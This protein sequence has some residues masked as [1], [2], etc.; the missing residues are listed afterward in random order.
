MDTE[1]GQEIIRKLSMCHALV[2]AAVGVA[3]HRI[4]GHSNINLQEPGR[5]G[6]SRGRGAPSCDCG[7][8]PRVQCR[9]ESGQT[10]GGHLPGK[11]HWGAQGQ[12]A[13]VVIQSPG[14]GVARVISDGRDGPDVRHGVRRVVF[15]QQHPDGGGAPSGGA[16]G[17]SQHVAVRDEGPATKRSFPR[18]AD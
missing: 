2:D 7:H 6:A 15:P 11:G 17:G 4:R 8:L 14:P 18:G 9:G 13:K 10:H 1:V 3:A 12:D 16:V 5:Q